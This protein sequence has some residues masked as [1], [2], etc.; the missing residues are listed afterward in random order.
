LSAVNRRVEGHSC[1][2][3]ADS[4]KTQITL[5]IALLLTTATFAQD[6]PELLRQSATTAPTTQTQPA[7]TQAAAPDLQP[8]LSK[9]QPEM[10]AVSQRYEADRGNLN[11][12]FTVAFSPQREARLRLF[13]HDWLA[14]LDALKT[15]SWSEEGKSQR[16]KLKETI[17]GELTKLDTEATDFA[18]VLPLLPFAHTIIELAEARLR[19]EPVDAQKSAATLHELKNQIEQSQKLLTSKSQSIGKIDKA[20]A[21]RAADT[22]NRLRANLRAWFS[23]YNDYDPLFTWWAAQSY[24]EADQALVAYANFLRDKASEIAGDPSAASSPTA[25]AL[26]AKS[27]PAMKRIGSEPDVPDLAELVAMPQSEMRGVIQAYNNRGGRG[28]GIPGGRGP[29]PRSEQ[30]YKDWL[31][32]LQKLDFDALSH[33]GKI[34]YILLRNRID[35]DLRRAQHREAGLA[36]DIVKDE[37]G[38]SGRP[39]GDEGL[40]IELSAEMI[41]YTP[42]ELIDIAQKEYI[43]CEAE[44]KKASREMGYGDDWKKAVEKVKTMY[45]PAGQQP[46]AIRDLAWEGDE[47]VQ[48][49]QMVTVPRIASETWRMEMMTPQ[50]QL[51]NPFFTGGETISVSYPT[52]TMSYDSKMESM[53]GNNIPFSHATVFHE[54]IPGHH[55]QGF[56]NSRYRSYRRSFN[57]PFWIEGWSLYWEMILYDRGFN[58]TPENRVGALFWRMHRCARIVFSLGFHSRKMTPQQCIDY[59]VDK[60]GHERQ[61]AAAEVRRSFNGSYT[62]LYQAAYM[63]GGLQIRELR[64]EMVGPSRMTEKQFHDALLKENS[65]PIA[66]MRAELEDQKLTR[67]YNSDWRFYG[68]HP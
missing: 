35:S 60:V 51:V 26:D 15:E 4:I 41:P 57:T 68:E 3:R 14:A 6:N 9:P 65:I 54:L 29:A 37:S 38:I 36:I 43:W 67:D 10:W 8:L 49:D 44:I 52:S 21:T 20:L 27:S 1:P 33:D 31:A 62:P 53:R 13:Y 32:N 34:D 12:F 45:V 42:A 64:K 55:L 56:M 5:I 24:K 47:Y 23:F 66:I 19:M 17:Q 16:D 59:L 30:Y 28:G 22:A 48:K 39:I 25:T 46:Y 2:S 11:R 50:R 40:Q 18:Q 61:N 63:L 58:Q 7:T